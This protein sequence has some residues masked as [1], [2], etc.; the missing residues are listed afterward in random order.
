MKTITRERGACAA[1][2]AALALC[3]APVQRDVAC[4]VASSQLPVFFEGSWQLADEFELFDLTGTVAA[5]TFV[6]SRP[7]PQAEEGAGTVSPA[8]F[9]AKARDRLTAAGKAVSGNEAELFGESRY[10][11]IVISADDTEPPVLR[12]YLGL[13]PH[14]VK[15]KDALAVV[16]KFKGGG[17]WQMRRRLMLGLFDE[18]F[19]CGNDKALSADVVV[20][21]RS[22]AVV[23]KAEAD[24]VAHGK[25]AAAPD[26]ERCRLCQEAWR[27]L[28]SASKSAAAKQPVSGNRAGKPKKTFANGA[29]EAEPL[30]VAP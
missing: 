16:S 5:Y 1:A 21:M 11:S 24:T 8:A 12:C 14:V 28:A 18:A 29:D 17:V 9:V 6:F 27:S 2:F 4:Q 3:A 20:E 30:Q 7:R 23:S 26:P 19:L 15:E 25:K 10:A 22:G 13:P